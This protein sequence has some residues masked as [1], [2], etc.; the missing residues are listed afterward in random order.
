V[1]HVCACVCG[2]I[3]SKYVCVNLCVCTERGREGEKERE[4]GRETHRE[5]ANL[6]SKTVGMDQLRNLCDEVM[7]QYED[8]Y[9]AHIAV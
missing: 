3:V 4:G 9:I 5:R 8:T 7:Q 6:Q 1:A 2:T